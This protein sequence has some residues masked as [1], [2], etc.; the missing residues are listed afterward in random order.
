M[1]ASLPTGTHSTLG[2]HQPTVKVLH[3]HLRYPKSA[4][5]WQRKPLPLLLTTSHPAEQSKKRKTDAEK[6][7]LDKVRVNFGK[8]FSDGNN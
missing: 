6:H 3:R 4:G 5:E 7:T 8:V 2:V 1:N